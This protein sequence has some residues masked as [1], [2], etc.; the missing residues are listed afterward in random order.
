[1]ERKN[2]KMKEFNNVRTITVLTELE[3]EKPVIRLGIGKYEVTRVENISPKDISG[4]R[5]GLC[6]YEADFRLEK[7]G[8]H[9]KFSCIFEKPVKCKIEKTKEDIA[10]LKCY[11]MPF[12]L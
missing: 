9:G 4:I 1:M 2:E 6:R 3:P 7:T 10:V 12:I 8:I 5:V 11:S